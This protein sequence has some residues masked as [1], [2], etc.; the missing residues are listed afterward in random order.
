[1]SSP[2]M[3]IRVTLA[4]DGRTPVRTFV[5]DGVE[6]GEVSLIELIEFLIQAPSTIRWEVER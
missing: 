6:I 5:F 1:M 4:E 3:A 2:K